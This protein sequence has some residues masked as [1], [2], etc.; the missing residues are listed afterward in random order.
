VKRRPEFVLSCD[1]VAARCH[2]A[3]GDTSTAAKLYRS[4]AERCLQNPPPTLDE[5]V[6]ELQD[7]DSDPAIDASLTWAGR[8]Q[9][10]AR[11]RARCEQ[12][13]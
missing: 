4:V 12:L 2:V 7:L 11:L 9:K 13:R 3:E 1:R 8:N 6:I 10:L 5:I